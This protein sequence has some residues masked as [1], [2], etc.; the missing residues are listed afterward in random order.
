MQCPKGRSRHRVGES[1]G[2]GPVARI[3]HP[4]ADHEDEQEIQQA[5]EREGGAGAL[6]VLLTREKANRG[7]EFAVAVRPAGKVDNLRQLC[8]EWVEATAVDPV[9][10]AQ[11]LRLAAIVSGTRACVRM[12]AVE[13][14]RRADRDHP[15]ERRIGDHIPFAVGQQQDDV[16]HTE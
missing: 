12:P 14:R 2:P 13:R 15:V 7:A 5:R 1:A 9:L 4:R 8:Q 11:H 10:P 6:L 16:T 3:G